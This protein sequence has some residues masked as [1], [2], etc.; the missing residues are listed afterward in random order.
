MRACL[1]L[2]FFY[3]TFKYKD[4]LQDSLAMFHEI[5]DD[6]RNHRFNSTSAKQLLVYLNKS[7]TMINE[8]EDLLHEQG[9]L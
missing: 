4:R 2:I 3:L 5:L 6:V 9:L 8:I 7:L 1:E